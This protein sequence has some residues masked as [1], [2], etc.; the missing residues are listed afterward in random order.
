MTVCVYDFAGNGV[1]IAD[2]WA[3][4]DPAQNLVV[5]GGCWADVPDWVVDH[6]PTE[7]EVLQHVRQNQETP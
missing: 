3:D 2:R 5:F 4:Y 7:A 6:E 1:D